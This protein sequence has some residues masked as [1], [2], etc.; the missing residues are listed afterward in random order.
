MRKPRN[1]AAALVIL[2]GMIVASAFAQ[3]PPSFAPG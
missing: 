2:A 3:A 1:V